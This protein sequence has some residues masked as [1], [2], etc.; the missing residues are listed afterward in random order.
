MTWPTEM[1]ASPRWQSG[2]TLKTHSVFT[3]LDYLYLNVTTNNTG[4][5]ASCSYSSGTW[6]LC[7]FANISKTV[8]NFPLW[9]IRKAEISLPELELF[10]CLI[11]S[12]LSTTSAFLLSSCRFVFLQFDSLHSQSALCSHSLTAVTVQSDLNTGEKEMFKSRRWTAS[13]F[14]VIW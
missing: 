2:R 4:A 5:N 7:C 10:Y 12:S 11:V 3:V 1:T 6:S 8:T 13:L 9:H 14:S